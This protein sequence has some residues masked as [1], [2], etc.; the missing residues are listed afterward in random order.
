VGDPVGAA[1]LRDHGDRTGAA[2]P[3]RGEVAGC[4]RTAAGEGERVAAVKDAVV[5]DRERPR[6]RDDR[7]LRAGVDPPGGGAGV[8]APGAAA[9]VAAPAAVVGRAVSP[10]SGSTMTVRSGLTMTRA[11]LP[12]AGPARALTNFAGNTVATLLIGMWPDGFDKERADHVLSGGDP[13]DE[14]TMLDDHEENAPP[15]EVGPPVTAQRT[16]AEQEPAVTRT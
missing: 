12:L 1:G 6:G 13:F 16:P 7:T 4:Q 2:V 9:P 8:A 14:A 10:G 11:L 3:T 5:A 15:S